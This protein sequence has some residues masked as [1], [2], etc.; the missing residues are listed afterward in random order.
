MARLKW[1]FF[2]VLLESFLNGIASD[3]QALVF[4]NSEENMGK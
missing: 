3:D 1:I 4:P 2:A